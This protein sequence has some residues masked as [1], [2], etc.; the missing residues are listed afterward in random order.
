VAVTVMQGLSAKLCE[1][2]E[3]AYRVVLAILEAA[4]TVLTVGTT[5]PGRQKQIPWR[6]E[7]GLSYTGFLAESWCSYSLVIPGK[8]WNGLHRKI[9]A[10]FDT[11]T[12]TQ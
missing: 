8:F 10:F 11:P 4:Q 1:Q 2:Y 3:R 6:N 7:L 5:W 9:F 12:T